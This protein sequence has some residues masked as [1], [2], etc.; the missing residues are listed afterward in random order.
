[1]K[2]QE[3]VNWKGRR[4]NRLGK[5]RLKTAEKKVEEAE[6]RSYWIEAVAGKQKQEVE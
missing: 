3:L 1:M 5:G 6:V 4:S 2:R